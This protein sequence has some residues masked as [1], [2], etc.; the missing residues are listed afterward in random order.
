MWILIDLRVG[1]L[2]CCEA[3]PTRQS[4]T[5]SC[6]TDNAICYQENLKSYKDTT[7][8]YSQSS[9]N[10]RPA[11]SLFCCYRVTPSPKKMCLESKQNHLPPQET[12]LCLV[13]PKMNPAQIE[14][15]TSTVQ[16]P[17][18]PV[19]T[20]TPPSSKKDAILFK[21]YLDNPIS[22]PTDDSSYQGLSM[23]NT[24]N[25][26]CQGICNLNEGRGY[27]YA[28]ELS[29]RVPISWRAQ[30]TSY[31]DFPPVRSAFVRYPASPHYT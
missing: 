29:L 23:M 17:P 27:D 24:N 2:Y 7:Q 3:S 25:N 19:T 13:K 22:K 18:A 28:L 6:C 16:T 21:P 4:C 12:P 20:S 11:S 10:K 15:V 9:D 8:Y 26:N 30:H 31:C 5:L 1:A 14:I